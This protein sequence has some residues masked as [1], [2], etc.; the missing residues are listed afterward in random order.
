VDITAAAVGLAL[1][2]VVMV[3]AMTAIWLED[4][5]SPLFL[6]PRAGRNGTG[7]K[8][9]KLRTMRV[10]AERTGVTSTASDDPRVTLL[11]RILRRWKVDELPQLVNVLKGDMSLVGP[12]PGVWPNVNRFTQEEREVLPVRPG[13]TDIASIVFAD[14]GDIV[15][16]TLDPDLV[17]DRVIRPWKSRLGLLYVRQGRT[18]WVDV[19][20]V[21]Y[22]V[23]VIFSRRLALKR[24][25]A[26][27]RE[28]GGGEELSLVALRAKPLRESSP[29]GMTEPGSDT[30]RDQPLSPRTPDSSD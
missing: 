18:W 10:G 20:L 12:R 30:A 13:I 16:G 1:G 24:V 23:L 8:M 26:L 2:A 6:S 15:R 22:T 29:P 25:S 5:H 28:L 17:Y 7:F 4:R 21:W 19:R 11:G 9:F 27:V 3:P 14:E